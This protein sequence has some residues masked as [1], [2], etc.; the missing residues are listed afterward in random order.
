MLIPA[1]ILAS[2]GAEERFQDAYDR[3]R[4]SR[5]EELTVYRRVTKKVNHPG[6]AE[7]TA[8]E[9]TVRAINPA[10]ECVSGRTSRRPRATPGG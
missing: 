4:L 6:P 8:W 1:I 7:G 9:G 5:V 3:R 2:G 10:R